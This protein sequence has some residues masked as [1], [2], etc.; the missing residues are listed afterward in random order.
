MPLEGLRMGLGLAGFF[1]L[2]RGGILRAG[3]VL[4]LSVAADWMVQPDIHYN[5]ACLLEEYRIVY[6]K[7]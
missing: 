5:N 7:R 2:I 3:T 6:N 1:L 4:G